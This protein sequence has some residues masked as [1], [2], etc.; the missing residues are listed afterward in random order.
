MAIDTIRRFERFPFHRRGS[1]VSGAPVGPTDNGDM[2]PGPPDQPE[3]VIRL[4]VSAPTYAVAERGL[5]ADLLAGMNAAL[6]GKVRLEAIGLIEPGGEQPGFSAADC[7]AVVALMRPRLASDVTP[8]ASS[9]ASQGGVSGVLSAMQ[10]RKASGDLPDIYIFR[11]ADPSESDTDWESRKHV[12]DSWFRA[13]GGKYLAF[14]DVFEPAEFAAKLESQLRSWLARLGQ[15]IATPDDVIVGEAMPP[16]EATEQTQPITA[17]D[18]AAEIEAS[19]EGQESDLAAEGVASVCGDAEATEADDKQQPV[20]D[21][22]SGTIPKP[23]SQIEDASI[24]EE[25]GE[26]AVSGIAASAAEAEAPTESDEGETSGD[27]GKAALGDADVPEAEPVA[28]PETDL[29]DEGRHD[30]EGSPPLPVTPEP[31][32]V[33]EG[34]ETSNRQTGEAEPGQLGVSDTQDT[35]A[36]ISEP[37]PENLPAPQEPADSP[38]R[39]D[40]PPEATPIFETT[41]PQPETNSPALVAAFDP[42]RDQ[43]E[44]LGAKDRVLDA[45]TDD[46]VSDALRREREARSRAE[47][48]R[49]RTRRITW[50]VAAAAIAVLAVVGVEWRSAAIRRDQAEQNLAAAADRAGTLVSELAKKSQQPN[51]GDDPSSKDALEKARSLLGDLATAG[52]VDPVERKAFADSLMSSS[53][54]LLKAGNVADALKAATQAQ[55]ILRTLSTNDP[56]QPELLARLAQCDTNIGEMYFTEKNP[57]EALG[58]FRDAMA[59][60]HAL[61]LKQPEDPEGQKSLAA[62]Q[63]RVG[64]MM[65]EKSRLDDALAVYREAQAIRKTLAQNNADDPAAQRA[66]IE[67]DDAVGDTLTAQNHMDDALGVYREEFAVAEHMAQKTPDEPKWQRALALDDNKI[68]DAL[69]AMERIDDALSAYRDGVAIVKTLAA[70]QPTSNEWQSM[71]ATGQERIGDALAAETHNESALSAYNET[72]AIV[73]ALATK[74]PSNAEWQR[75]ISETELRIGWALFKQGKIDASI[76]AH[77]ESL[78][79]VKAMIAKQPDNVRWRRDLMLDDGKIAQLLMTQGRHADALPLYEEALAV[80]KEMGPKD[81][82]NTEWLSTRAVIDSNVGRLLMETGKRDEAM[83]AYHDARAT[84]EALVLKEPASVDSQTGLVIAYYNL[85]EAGEDTNGNL[86]RANDILKRLDT[87]GVLPADKKELIGKIDE[88]L[89]SSTRQ[90]KHR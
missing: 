37:A 2:E 89:E 27:S 52:K 80:A 87:A 23:A 45:E 7:D 42:E 1:V 65:L 88:E 48:A 16:A 90:I 74:D 51:G 44:E 86:L 56:N 50:A 40:R 70:K 39:D 60:R 43:P 19:G 71:L 9:D 73:T 30:P 67:I 17:L 79:V 12:F 21:T 46:A 26:V 57:D 5:I 24:A 8:S 85:A 36:P 32:D 28:T 72:L 69:L 11:Y 3:E 14:E 78:A 68:G 55:E 4:F 13:R 53:D 6:A 41:S 54:D 25:P 82:G 76:A 35:G 58:S 18:Q 83:V 81:P 62:V 75:G 10:G 22:A 31:E 29:L 64:D 84:A 77:R 33:S 20:H 61:V 47:A 49:R 38:S 66:L 34:S 59:I 63:Q 15:D